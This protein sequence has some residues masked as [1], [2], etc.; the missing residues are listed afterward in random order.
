MPSANRP[1]RDRQSRPRLDWLLPVIGVVVLLVACVVVARRKHLWHDEVF[2]WIL[3]TD[4]S[5]THMLG[6][7]AGGAEA[8]PPLYHLTAR[9][10]L[11]IAGQSELALRLW[12]SVGFALSLIVLWRVLRRSYDPTV[13]AAAAVVPF[14]ISPLLWYQNAEARFYGT[15]TLAAALAFAATDLAARRP[16]RARLA[17]VALAHAALVMSHIFGFF[18]GGALLGGLAVRDAIAL[19]RGRPAIGRWRPYAAAVAGWLPFALWIPAFITQAEVGVPHSWIPVPT[20]RALRQAY[21]TDG[22]RT[23]MLVVLGAGLLAWVARHLHRR[24][25]DEPRH[26]TVAGEPDPLPWL[27]V[28]VAAVPLGVYVISHVAMSVFVDRYMLPGLFA[29]GVAIAA[30]CTELSRAYARWRGDAQHRVRIGARAVLVG[31]ALA[32]LLL[33]LRWAAARQE[34]PRPGEALVRAAGPSTPIVTESP[35]EYLPVTYYSGKPAAPFFFA[36]DWESALAPDAALQATVDYKMMRNWRRWGFLADGIVEADSI[37]CRLPRFVVVDEP[38]RLWYD[39]HIAGDSAFSTRTLYAE[40]DS[41]TGWWRDK[42]IVLVERR[43]LPARCAPVRS[44][45]GQ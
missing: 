2:S 14:A 25:R 3:V 33:P 12:S 40:R 45:P 19:A 23:F 29:Y 13:A 39:R 16:S 41:A 22:V 20:R 5:A 18:Y 26:A 31:L 43:T 11:A 42:R 28:A 44:P 37:L 9:L 34:F 36:L 17:G 8:A 7:I 10:W 30:A 24:S 35:L 15:F 1:P 27:A 4:P 21:G 32:S 6:A 38:G